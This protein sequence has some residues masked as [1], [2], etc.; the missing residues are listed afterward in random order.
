V[1]LVH[2]RLG[3]KED[4]APSGAHAPASRFRLEAVAQR[5]AANPHAACDVAGAG[6]GT[7]DAP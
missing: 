7:T 2:P 3:R 6:N 1:L 4:S 5:V